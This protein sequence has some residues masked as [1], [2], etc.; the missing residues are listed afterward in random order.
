M[1]IR[2]FGETGVK[3]RV[4]LKQSASG[5]N[6]GEGLQNVS[7]N[8]AGLEVCVARD[9]SN[10]TVAYLQSA[11]NIEAVGTLGI[12]AAPSTNKCRI[13]KVSDTYH[14]G[15]VE[16]Q[17]ADS[18]W[19]A[20]SDGKPVRILITVLGAANLQECNY[21][22]LLGDFVSQASIITAMK[23][24]SA[25]LSEAS[26][27]A[28]TAKYQAKVWLVKDSGGT[29][30]RYLV[31]FFK[32]SEPVYSGITNAAIW[33]YKN[34]GTDLV[35][36]SGSPVSLTQIGSSGTYTHNEATNRIVSGQAYFMKV[37]ATIGGATRSWPQP[38]SRDN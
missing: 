20:S 10:S 32:N 2:T 25:L 29:A 12:W 1:D 11:N 15:A 18:H 37:T 34:D 6:P 4:V 19:V 35:G 5:S 28:D 17:F 36:T 31:A 14:P 24:E 9:D 21:E 26:F 33:I 27:A 23:S 3:V 22:I 13:L 30:D 8:T 7:Y 16:L 38:I